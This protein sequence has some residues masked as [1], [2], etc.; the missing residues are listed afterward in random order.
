MFSPDMRVPLRLARSLKDDS[1]LVLVLVGGDMPTTLRANLAAE[2]KNR[3]PGFWN[4]AK[5]S[6]MLSRLLP[7]VSG[8]MYARTMTVNRASP[9]KRK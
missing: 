5:A 4:D 3:V 7:L 2:L 1:E 9:P 6:C 8:I